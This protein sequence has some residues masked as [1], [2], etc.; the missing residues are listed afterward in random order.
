[1]A[2]SVRPASRITLN[3]EQT[4][5]LDNL[6]A[7]IADP[8]PVSNFFVLSGFAGTGKTFLMGEVVAKSTKSRIK[9]AFTAPTNKAAKV[10]R[11]I[12][13]SACTTF[14]LLGLRID[15]SGEVKKLIT[16]EKPVDLSE[17][18]VIWVDEGS[19]VGEVLHDI[20]CDQANFNNIKV[21][22]MGDPAQ[23]PPVK[24][25]ASKIWTAGHPT[26]YLTKVERHDNQILTL[27][28]EIRNR[29]LD[30]SPSIKIA[31]DRSMT[32]DGSDWQGVLKLAK[33]E[34]KREIA[35]AADAGVFLDGSLGK[36]IAWRN[37]RVDEYNDLIRYAIFGGAA[38]RGYYLAGDRIIAASPCKKTDDETLL[39]TDDE[40]IVESTIDCQ[41]P[42]APEYKA[43]ELRCRNESNK[44]IRLLV[45][46]PES[47][48]KY[49]DDCTILAHNAKSNPRLWKKF[50]EQKDLFHEI[51]Y[52]YAITAHRSQGSTYQTVFVD[53]PDILG[54]RNR[55]EAF[56]CLY[57]ACSRPTTRLIVT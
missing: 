49:N 35:K 21:V 56:Q 24:E 14:S 52:A 2:V 8:D 13:G 18:H 42:F 41:H 27:V 53:T 7:F 33:V 29:M 44:Q 54:N 3:H 57:V 4:T 28:T 48:E 25:I 10:L 45:I 43:I 16:S 40:A 11:G 34:F 55:K 39:A 19:M 32:E 47:L 1:M 30:F 12:A 36:V 38:S 51:K 17:I 15:K 5:A 37:A 20:L 9:F 26:S 6:L 31:T 23:L 22:F 50:W 46:H